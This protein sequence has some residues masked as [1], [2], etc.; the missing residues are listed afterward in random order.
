MRRSRRHTTRSR[1]ERSRRF[2]LHGKSSCGVGRGRVAQ[3][4]LAQELKKLFARR[5]RQPPK[6]ADFREDS[7]K[8][9]V[10]YFK[11]VAV[12]FGA[13]WNGRSYCSI[14]SATALRAF[15]RVSPDVV[16]RLD[17]DHAERSD[18]RAIGR[19]IAPWGA[20]SATSASRQRARGNAAV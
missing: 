7:R 16:R 18:F 17:Q 19:V 11:Q 9:F 13:A 15:V 6:S 2:T 4:P 8:F 1:V 10:N 12:V 5:I 14:K 3:A 20:A